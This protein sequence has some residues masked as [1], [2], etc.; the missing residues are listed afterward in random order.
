MTIHYVTGDATY[1]IGDGPK[2]IAH[3]CNDIGAWGAGFVKALDKRWDRPR[4]R[5]KLAHQVH[6]F[7]FIGTTGIVKVE[8]D[9]EVANM[10][11]QVGVRGPN[12]P[13]PIRYH[14][15]EH[16]LGVVAKDAGGRASV[17][18]PRIGCGLAGGT[19]DEV[20]PII[21]RTLVAAGVPVTVYDLEGPR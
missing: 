15:L 16:C 13:Q 2:I 21:Q 1:P 20:E 18:M 14:V 4:E 9:I 3:V 19:W 12:N 17:H 10:V 11:A 8:P 5:Y 6:P 7:G